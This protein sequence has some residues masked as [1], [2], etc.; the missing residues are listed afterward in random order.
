VPLSLLIQ[1]RSPNERTHVSQLFFLSRK[2]T[3][4]QLFVVTLLSAVVISFQ[5]IPYQEFDFS[6]EQGGDTIIYLL[7]Q[8]FSPLIPF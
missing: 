1:I 6:L 4:V 3:E 2:E 7:P 8:V 5:N